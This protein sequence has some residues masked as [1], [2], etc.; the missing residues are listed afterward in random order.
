MCDVKYIQGGRELQTVMHDVG[1]IK[2]NTAGPAFNGRAHYSE[3]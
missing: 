3:G 2:I 1:E